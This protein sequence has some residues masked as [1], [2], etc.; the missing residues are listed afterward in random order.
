MGWRLTL[1]SMLL[2]FAGGWAGL[3]LA[4]DIRPDVDAAPGYGLI[5]GAII[6]AI[7]GCV[8]VLLTHERKPG[9]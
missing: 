6:G 4:N 9:D 7:A 8:F 2:G 1:W 3:Y 5:F